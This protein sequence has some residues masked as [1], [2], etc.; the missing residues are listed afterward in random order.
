MANLL[1]SAI[2]IRTLRRAACFLAANRASNPFHRS[3]YVQWDA[4]KSSGNFDFTAFLGSLNATVQDDLLSFGTL[5]EQLGC[6]KDETFEDQTIYVD[7]TSGSDTTGDGSLARPFQSMGFV[8]DLPH[9]INHVLNMVLLSNVTENNPLIFTHNIGPGGCI[10]IIGQ[11]PPTTVVTS[12]GAGPFTLTGVTNLND[13]GF[14]LATAEAWTADELYGYW[15]LFTTGPFVGFACPIAGNDAAGNVYT[16]DFYSGSP[17][18]GNQ[19]IVVRPGHTL[20]CPAWDLNCKAPAML[21]VFKQESRFGIY[22][23]ELAIG[24]GALWQER[25]FNV[26]NE[27]H[28]SL[29]FVRVGHVNLNNVFALD[30]PI[31]YDLNYDTA[32]VPT[33]ANTGITNLEWDTAN[34]G[35]VGLLLYNSAWPPIAN[36]VPIEA[37]I[38]NGITDQNRSIWGVTGRGRWAL[39]GQYGTLQRCC[40]GQFHSLYN[41][42][43][44][45]S[46]CLFWGDVDNTFRQDSGQNELSFCYFKSGASCIQVRSGDIVLQGCSSGGAGQFTQ[47]GIQ[48]TGSARVLTTTDPAPLVGAAGQLDFPALGASLHPVANNTQ[49]AD[50]LGNWE[51]WAG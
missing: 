10:N 37:T 30:S 46:Y 4:W 44:R 2:G 33:L 40:A 18:V 22:N 39:V 38:G 32:N 11:G 8:S 28:T 49:T 27:C 23:L 29:S 3:F 20:S 45:M 9:N 6:G 15:I 43:G 47:F 5:L 36:Y 14:E 13:A 21:S 41:A 35:N 26:R 48:F 16:R 31:N 17:G 51:T 7:G 1:Q 19:F 50:A 25:T 34:G 24:G 42:G 12:T